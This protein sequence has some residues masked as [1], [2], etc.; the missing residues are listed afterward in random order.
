MQSKSKPLTAS[1][2]TEKTKN[3]SLSQS[4]LATQEGTTPLKLYQSINKLPFNKFLE[5]VETNDLSLLCIE[6]EATEEILKETW[7]KL[8]ADYFD[9]VNGDKDDSET[10]E[11]KTFT[12]AYNKVCRARAVLDAIVKVGPKEQL[13]EALYAFDYDLPENTE[14]N[15]ETIVKLFTA[16][17]KRD[18][19]D[20]QVNTKERDEA[21]GEAQVIDA[22]YY[23]ET[24][25]IM[26][27]S[28]KCS[29]DMNSLTLGLYAALIKQ[30]KQHCKSLLKLQSHAN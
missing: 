12:I 29:I 2:L 18:Y 21:K 19:I 4:T 22:N 5:I 26:M 3:L 14:K 13:I 8:N 17:H 16:N 15:V 1:T 25:A 30:Y 20:L 28:L 10:I 24:I 7:D 6:G 11:A 27:T 9:V 23:L